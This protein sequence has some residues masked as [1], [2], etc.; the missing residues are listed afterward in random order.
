MTSFLVFP[1]LFSSHFSLPFI[2]L[3]YIPSSCLSLSSTSLSL[4]PQSFLPFFLFFPLLVIHFY[5]FLCFIHPLLLFLLFSFPFL[6][7]WPP[8]PPLCYV[9]GTVLSWA[10]RWWWWW[11]WWWLEVVVVVVVG[12]GCRLGDN[13]VSGR[14]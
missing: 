8:H 1:P 3:F 2:P 9:N 14:R 4:F 11:W 13:S 5:L 7:C 10:K 12:S 6:R